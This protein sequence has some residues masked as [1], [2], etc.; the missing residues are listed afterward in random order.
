MAG[1]A[2]ISDAPLGSCGLYPQSFRS[3]DFD[4]SFTESQKI[5]FV[6]SEKSLRAGLAGT[7]ED[8]SVVGAAARH[9]RSFEVRK[10]LP[11]FARIERHHA[12]FRE[13]VFE[14]GR[15]ILRAQAMRRREPGH[16]GIGFHQRR[17]RE[18]QA[19]G[20]QT[21][22]QSP[23]RGF[24]ILMPAEQSGDNDARVDRLAIHDCRLRSLRCVSR[25]VSAD[26]IPADT[27]TATATRPFFTLA[28]GCGAGSISTRPS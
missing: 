1:A 23:A 13:S 11:D 8:M 4:F 24:V 19:L 25:T 9:L 27:A 14:Q 15:G 10:K 3:H 6:Q 2:N 18:H 16:H 20:S 17:G 28:T 22:L 21:A 12:H 5:A 7:G 26:N